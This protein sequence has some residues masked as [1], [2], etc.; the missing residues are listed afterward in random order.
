MKNKIKY[1]IIIPIIIIIVGVI[2]SIIPKGKVENKTKSSVSKADIINFNEIIN[3]NY[4]RYVHDFSEG[5]PP[6]YYSGMNLIIYKTK[7]EE[8]KLK[9]QEKVNLGINT[10]FIVYRYNRKELDTEL[11]SLY[12]V[13][14]DKEY[15]EKDFTDKQVRIINENEVL[16]SIPTTE[17]IFY[18]TSVKKDNNKYTIE[19]NEYEVTSKNKKELNDSIKKGIE[20]KNTKINNKY[21]M[22]IE[23]TNNN[24]MLISKKNITNGEGVSGSE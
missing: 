13:E 10:K 24:Y 9:D 22:I 20:P 23:K 16:Y 21:R 5:Y 11:E 15:E 2:I 17:Y 1:I 14:I 18:T 12:K 3:D 6:D 7:I 19:T 8:N 4:Y